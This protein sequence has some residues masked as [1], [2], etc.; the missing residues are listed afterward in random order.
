MT[1]SDLIRERLPHAPQMGLYVAPNL[2]AEKVQRALSTYAGMVER[3]DFLAL[4]DATL[5]GTGGN[6]ATFTS[7]R[8][9]FKNHAF[10]SVQTV[11]YQDLVGVKTANQW[12][13][14]GGKEV[15]LT[16][17]R[18]RATFDLTMDF[19][20]APEAADYVA[21]VLHDIMVKGVDLDDGTGDVETDVEAVRR[22][23]DTLRERGAL[24]DADYERLMSV[25]DAS[26]RES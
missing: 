22:A 9:I 7:D 24:A 2:P 16:V 4:Y 19:S 18:G 10:Q 21:E 8:L 11:R 15:Q 3:D 20:G 25:L 12:L 14:L 26:S 17:N 5:L 23:L 6:G 1:V 13:G